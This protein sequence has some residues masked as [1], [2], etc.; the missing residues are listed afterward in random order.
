MTSSNEA[1]INGS[2]SEKCLLSVLCVR[3]VE[4]EGVSGY[5][6]KTGL[7]ILLAGVVNLNHI[8]QTVSQQLKPTSF[9]P[10]YLICTSREVS[11]PKQQT[12]A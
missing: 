7:R 1:N 9:H 8:K 11:S 3:S 10:N 5:E 12:P 6:R 4:G 2:L